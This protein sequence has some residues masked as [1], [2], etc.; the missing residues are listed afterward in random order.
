MKKYI[1]RR[2]SLILNPLLCNVVQKHHIKS[3]GSR[4][5]VKS[6]LAKRK[7]IYNLTCSMRKTSNFIFFRNFK[8]KRKEFLKITQATNFEKSFYVIFNSIYKKKMDGIPS[9]SFYNKIKIF[10]NKKVHSQDYKKVNTWM[11]RHQ[12]ALRFFNK[13]ERKF[14]LK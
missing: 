12:R 1:R 7:Q 10:M 3:G 9:K 4:T 8:R 6:Y 5:S 14:K 11:H 2:T 13:E